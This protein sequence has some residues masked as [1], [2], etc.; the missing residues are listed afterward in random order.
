M[1]DEQ[2]LQNSVTHLSGALIRF[3]LVVFIFQ[4]RLPS[5]RSLTDG[6]Q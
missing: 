5:I 1:R 3:N 2:Q 4:F 6:G